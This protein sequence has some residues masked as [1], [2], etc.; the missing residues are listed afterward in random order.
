MLDQGNDAS[1]HFEHALEMNEGMGLRPW[2]AHTQHDYAQLLTD[3]GQ[4]QQ[5]AS[6]LDAAAL[7]TYRDLGISPR[8]L[9][10]SAQILR[11]ADDT[12]IINRRG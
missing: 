1:R 4:M 10:Q 9:G 12:R 7:S 5:R 3:R 2:L 6:E 11:H 8:S